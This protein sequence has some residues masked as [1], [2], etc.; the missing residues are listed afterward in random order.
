DTK[1]INLSATVLPKFPIAGTI[2]GNVA[3]SV[4]K[5]FTGD[6]H[7]GGLLLSLLYKI[8]G[9]WENFSVDRQFD[10][11]TPGPLKTP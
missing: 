4:T 9:T 8:T 2:I 11:A 10:R 3:N 6:E 1:Q 5:T 7:A